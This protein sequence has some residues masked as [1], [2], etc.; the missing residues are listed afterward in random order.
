MPVDAFRLE[1]F[2]A[3]EDTGWIELRKINLLLGRNSSG[4]SA[5]IRAL[6]LMKQSWLNEENAG[7]SLTFRIE[8]GVDVGSFD[9][10]RHREPEKNQQADAHE[11]QPIQQEVEDEQWRREQFTFSYRGHLSEREFEEIMWPIFFARAK[12][13]ALPE[14][15]VV[16]KRE[17]WP[18][19]QALLRQFVTNEQEQPIFHVSA[20]YRKHKTTGKSYVWKYTLGVCQSLD[21]D[22]PAPICGYNV[23]TEKWDSFDIYEYVKLAPD[24]PVS[25]Q[26][27]FKLDSYTRFL[28]ELNLYDELPDTEQRQPLEWIENFGQVCQK[29][30]TNWLESI[31][32]VGPIR[33]EP[34]RRY[35][36]TEEYQRKL[37]LGGWQAFLNYLKFPNRELEDKVNRWLDI[38]N[39]GKKLDRYGIGFQAGVLD[40]A[41]LRMD[42]TGNGDW[43]ELVDVGFGA[44]QILPVIMQCQAAAENALI[45]IE[46]P[47]LHLHPEAQA[48]V[49]DMFIESVNELVPP[50]LEIHNRQLGE[51]AKAAQQEERKIPVTRRY[52][53]ET[54]SEHFMLSTQL[55]IA[56]RVKQKA[57]VLAETESEVEEQQFAGRD[58]ALLFITRDEQQG[59]SSIEDIQF[60]RFGRFMAP[61]SA[62]RSFFS[63]DYKDA[64]AFSLAVAEAINQGSLGITVRHYKIWGCILNPTLKEPPRVSFVR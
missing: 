23:E 8:G 48:D 3:F 25:L 32:H 22:E 5:I 60:D 15:F 2:M 64:A 9:T 13:G 36:L 50:R 12:K 7:Q 51:A 63:R 54:H 49:A 41:R 31:V 39:L 43:R 21:E 14:D 57:P 11:N 35:D 10:V 20:S 53:V 37:E 56:E 19:L 46:Q 58:F 30:V 34:Q 1:N 4:K 24:A 26:N 27:V 18:G 40:I 28:P 38:L 52:L 16:W 44:S 62:F 55:K 59:I 42:E 61:S 29:V 33:P 17:A 6:R 47:E 45:L